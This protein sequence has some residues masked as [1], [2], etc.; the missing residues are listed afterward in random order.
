MDTATCENQRN[1]GRKNSN[2][3]IKRNGS[4]WT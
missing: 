1:D 3:K 2:V 4:Y